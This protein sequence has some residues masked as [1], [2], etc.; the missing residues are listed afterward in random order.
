MPD[1]LA[2]PVAGPMV[3]EG[4][5]LKDYVVQLLPSDVDAIRHAVIFFK[6]KYHQQQDQVDR[7]L[8]SSSFQASQGKDQQG[9]I[10]LTGLIVR[11][12]LCNQQRGAQWTRRRC[13]SRSGNPEVQR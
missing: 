10:P 5:E 12:A 7:W 1:T 13:Y 3:W 6:R 4:G 11:Q 2:P 9:S 8:N